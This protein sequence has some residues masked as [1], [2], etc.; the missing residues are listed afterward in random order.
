MESNTKLKIVYRAMCKEEYEETVKSKNAVFYKRFK[1][2]SENLEFIM[3][4]VR[5]GK[6]NNSTHDKER[7]D[8]ILKFEADLSKAQQLNDNEIQF[9]RRRNPTIRLV[10]Q[11]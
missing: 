3:N 10:G 11:V 4:R 6:F 5:D 2:F 7:Y 1:W 9:D 8:F